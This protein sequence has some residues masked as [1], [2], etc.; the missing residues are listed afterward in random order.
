M[1]SGSGSMRFGSDG[2]SIDRYAHMAM[3]RILPGYMTP[4]GH[5]GASLSD[6]RSYLLGAVG[7]I[8]SSFGDFAPSQFPAHLLY[9]VDDKTAY[10]MVD[11]WRNVT[12]RN[13]HAFR[14][15]RAQGGGDNE[16]INVKVRPTSY[17]FKLVDSGNYAPIG[18]F[19]IEDGGA[20]SYN[21]PKAFIPL[22]GGRDNLPGIPPRMAEAYNHLHDNDV[23][24]QRRLN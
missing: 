15:A 13:V 23:F 12:T 8:Q 7:R 2:D 3:Q 4:K 18:F 16:M 24:R 21:G 1:N 11:F 10:D 22:I 5:D 19:N 20:F 14:T 9:K 6:Y 17:G